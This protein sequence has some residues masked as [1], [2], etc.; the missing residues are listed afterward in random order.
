MKTQHPY[1]FYFGTEYIKKSA[2]FHLT[3]FGY[4]ETLVFLLHLHNCRHRS[5][6]IFGR[7]LY[8][9]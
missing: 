6:P 5:T 1:S 7:V 3:V 2:F 9:L 8:L 4:M